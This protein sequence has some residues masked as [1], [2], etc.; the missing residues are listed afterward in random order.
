M[1]WVNAI[2]RIF[3]TPFVVTRDEKTTWS[4]RGER[5]DPV[6]P[7]AESLSLS[8]RPRF[9]THMRIV[10]AR[11]RV[12]AGEI[13]AAAPPPPPPP[14][15]W[16]E[17]AAAV[18]LCSG[19][20]AAAAALE[21]GGGGGGGS[22][23]PE[24][25]RE[26]TGLPY[27]RWSRAEEPRRRPCEWRL[28]IRGGGGLWRWI[29]LVIRPDRSQALPQVQFPTCFPVSSLPQSRSDLHLCPLQ[30]TQVK[31]PSSEFY[32]GGRVLFLS[33][34]EDEEVRRRRKRPPLRH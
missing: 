20:P 13:A 15:A 11:R 25:F 7:T 9:V 10:A 14:P 34:V 27:R 16:A 3:C 30:T 32:R 26:S 17:S 2:G 12:T 5:R 4:R 19:G 31:R 21:R 22:G 29:L 24:E 1:I 33:L 8:A 28:F 23:G 6:G 18:P